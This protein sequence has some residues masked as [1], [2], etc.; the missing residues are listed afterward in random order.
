VRNWYLPV[1]TGLVVGVAAHLV[2]ILIMPYQAPSDAWTRLSAIGPVNAVTMVPPAAPGR[3]LMPAVDPAFV[4]AACRYDLSGGAMKLRVPVTPDYTAITFYTRQGLAFY[5]INDRAAGRR[6]IELELMTPQQRA[7]LPPDEEIT[8]A[9]RLIV[10]SP[11]PTGMA[12]IRA[13]VRER[14][15][16]PAVEDAM[17]R[18][19]CAPD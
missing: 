8:A 13:L 10:E 9:D 1:A 2:A 11:S 5:A 6:L 14:G 16:R 7:Q 15:M 4:V 18:A 12:L 19:S 17:A 3:E